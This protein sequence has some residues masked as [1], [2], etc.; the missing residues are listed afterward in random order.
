LSHA[1][2]CRGTGAARQRSRHVRN[3][4]RRATFTTDQDV[5]QNRLILLVTL[6][7]PSYRHLRKDLIVQPTRRLD[8]SGS[9]LMTLACCAADSSVHRTPPR[10]TDMLSSSRMNSTLQ[11]SGNG[12]FRRR[13]RLASSGGDRFVPCEGD[14]DRV[15]AGTSEDKSRTRTA[16][17]LCRRGRVIRDATPAPRVGRRHQQRARPQLMGPGTHWV[18]STGW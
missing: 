15:A 16:T 1:Y 14:R 12:P 10:L 5:V 6:S 4:R 3:V 11:R 13:C 7:K 9:R 8:R 2:F 17:V 18:E